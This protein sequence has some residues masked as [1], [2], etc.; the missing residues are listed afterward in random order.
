MPNEFR[1]P[2]F[3]VSDDYAAALERVAVAEIG[4]DHDLYGLGLRAVAKCEGCDRA[5][6]EASDG[7]W[8]IVHL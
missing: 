5:V 8:A 3:A 1:E 4:P 7:T 2:W 6:F